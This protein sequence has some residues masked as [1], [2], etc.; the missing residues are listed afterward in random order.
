M[1]L[2][3][4]QIQETNFHTQKAWG[5]AYYKFRSVTPQGGEPLLKYLFYPRASLLLFL[6]I[7]ALQCEWGMRISSVRAEGCSWY[8][9]P[10][11]CLNP[12]SNEASA[13]RLHIQTGIGKQS[14]QRK[15]SPHW[16]FSANLSSNGLEPVPA[17]SL[18]LP[19]V[20]FFKSKM[21]S[22]AVWV[23]HYDNFHTKV[24]LDLFA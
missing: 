21:R 10:I 19:S 3:G 1:V 24:L 4:F 7:P 11:P 18:L 16:G 22:T 12:A 20:F 5:S 6:T 15:H 17:G 8:T 14:Q 23:K 9:Y 13:L 2:F